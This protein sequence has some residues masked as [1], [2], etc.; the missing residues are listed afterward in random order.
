ME[1]GNGRRELELATL[2]SKT[3]T[4]LKEIAKDMGISGYSTMKKHELTM[5][6]LEHQTEQS[7]LMFR[8]GVLEILPDGYGFL[9]LN[10]YLPGPEDVYVSPSQ[11][12]RFGMK[13]GD[14]VSGQV[15]APKETERYFSLLRIE[16]INDMDPEQARLR[17]DFEKLTPIH[18]NE[19]FNLDLEPFNTSARIL[20]LIAPIGRGQRALIVAPAKAGKTTLL[21]TIANAIVATAPNS[22]IIV[23][24]IDER[25]EEVTDIQRSVK[26][27][28]VASTFDEQAENHM[29]VSE[30]VLERAKR[31]L[32]HG[33]DV[34][35]LLDS[36]TRLSR[37]SNLTVTPSGRTL[38]GGLDPAAMYRPKRFFGAARNIEDGGSITI[39][40]TCLVDTGSRMD[41]MIYE[42]FKG[43]GNCDIFLDRD[44]FNRRIFPAIDIKKSSTR[45]EELLRN[46]EELRLIWRIR[47]VLNT[48][49]TAEAT[50]RLIEQTKKTRSNRDLLMQ[51]A[52]GMKRGAA[53]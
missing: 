5:K 42:E 38:A 32:E 7:G 1:G 16:A 17:K 12:K 29:R 15:R 53:I 18:P 22:K 26:A 14:M 47:D 25:P 21:K 40:A 20:D 50:E 13:T 41:D 10:G 46:G 28:V 36:L 19:K 27:E 34:V 52:E 31:L 6:I 33:H 51:V 44:L 48:F 39:I 49:D 45:H 24:L 43:T 8:K 2:E 23:L 4:E 30:M 3:L 9:R 37:A 35:I 11:I